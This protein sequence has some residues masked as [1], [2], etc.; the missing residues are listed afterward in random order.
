[1]SFHPTPVF[2][3]HEFPQEMRDAAQEVYLR[4]QAPPALIGTSFLT[5]TA[6]AVQGL[7]D[8][9]LP[10][11]AIAPVA[12]NAI[13][14][15]ESGERKSAV[16]G[17]VGAPL[18]DQDEKREQLY[19]ERLRKFA[20]DYQ[21]WR[22]ERDSL[23]R[24]LAREEED[25]DGL[26]QK[27]EKHLNAQPEKPH[28]RRLIRNDATM[29]PIMNSLAGENESVF[30]TSDEGDLALN[31]GVMSKFGFCNKLWESPK[32][33][34]IDR[35]DTVGLRARSPRASVSIMVQPQVWNDYLAKKG[36]LMR[37]SG[38]FARYLVID[39]PSTQ[40]FRFTH[41][42][43]PEWIHLPKYHDSIREFLRVYDERMERADYKRTLLQ[44]SPDAARLWV[45]V[46]NHMETAVRPD[47]WFYDIK[48]FVAKSMQIA[49]RIAALF[50]VVSK[51]EGQISLDTM[52]RAFSV[53][54]WYGTEFKRIFGEKA[55]LP[56]A[57][58]D[59]DTLARY[60][61]H[62]F[63]CRGVV[64]IPKNHVLRTG[65]IRP[66]QRM[67]AALN[68][69]LMS[70]IITIRVNSRRQRFIELNGAA[71]NQMNYGNVLPYVA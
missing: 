71:F 55:A 16:D 18:V 37:G 24:Q 9:Q 1:M 66:V 43:A 44:L 36:S 10:F 7:F 12:L 15:A 58:V 41:Y 38:A 47:A 35:A 49:A 6:A 53:V 29:R 30:I 34:A 17:L 27:L 48:D 5:S 50:H 51:Q 19:S 32:L 62:Q 65:P 22:I 13:T 28:L 59:A 4:V 60:F 26:K 33:L 8:V 70:N 23:V 68:L 69:I 57:E 39:P 46:S 11:G 2:P 42:P 63:W 25:P 61:F 45:D 67:E 20:M 54:D 40:G 3:T 21:I 52:K 56:Q 64:M 14:L 31:S